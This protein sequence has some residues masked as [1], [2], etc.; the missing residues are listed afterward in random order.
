[1]TGNPSTGGAGFQFQFPSAILGIPT[2]VW[3]GVA[4][5]FILRKKGHI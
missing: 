3:L 1:M 4:V 5:Y 2:I